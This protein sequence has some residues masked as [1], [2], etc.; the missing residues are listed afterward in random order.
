MSGRGP[1][2]LLAPIPAGALAG[3]GHGVRLGVSGRHI[4]RVRLTHF[5]LGL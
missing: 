5:C 1:P 3:I 4:K 2:S